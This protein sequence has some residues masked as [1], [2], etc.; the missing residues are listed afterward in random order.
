MKAY[1]VDASVAI[2]W[3]V[4]E[5][6]SEAAEALLTRQASGELA[7]HVPDLF[8]AEAGNIL[9]KKVR[10]GRLERHAAREIVD[11]LLAVPKTVHPAD[12]LLPGALDLA[13]ASGRT[14]YDSLYLTLSV[15]LGCPLMTADEKLRNALQ[16]TV[17]QDFVRWIGEDHPRKA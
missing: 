15:S 10:A 2:K 12:A 14:V 5:A 11:L 9:W 8:S 4:P 1:V 13:L 7:F 17:W 6:Y 3:F 16:G